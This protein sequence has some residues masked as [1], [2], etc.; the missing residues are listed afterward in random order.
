MLRELEP[1]SQ[2]KMAIGGIAA[3]YGCTGT[4]LLAAYSTTL[5]IM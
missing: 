1:A 4:A 2:L 3:A 5:S